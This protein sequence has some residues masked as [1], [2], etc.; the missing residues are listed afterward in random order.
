MS[1]S[2]GLLLKSP[3]VIHCSGSLGEAQFELVVAQSVAVMQHSKH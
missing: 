3:D 1:F 2:P